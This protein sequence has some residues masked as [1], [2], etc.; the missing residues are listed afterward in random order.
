[1][2]NAKETLKKIADALNVVSNDESKVEEVI[3]TPETVEAQETPE[4]A[5]EVV[6]TPEAT[7]G[8]TEVKEEVKETA[9]VVAET[10][11][12]TK[13]EEKDEVK[14]DD[15]RVK[16]LEAQIESLKDIISK[17]LEQE[18]VKQQAPEVPTEEPKGLTHSP[19]KPVRTKANG[20]GSKGGDIKSRVFKYIN[21][22]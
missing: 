7:E 17:S 4:V 10:T 2:L 19:E 1:M 3:E 16:E 12:E 8:T 18:E 11:E 13:V 6:E 5:K 20:I 21:N 14:A 9:E 22:N 15:S